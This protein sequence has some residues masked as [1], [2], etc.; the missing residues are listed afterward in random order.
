MAHELILAINAGSTSLKFGVYGLTPEGR[1]IE[2]ARGAVEEGEGGHLFV[3]ARA[4]DGRV[5]PV[6]T[7]PHAAGEAWTHESLATVLLE[8]TEQVM[9][10]ARVVAVGH[11]VVHGGMHFSAPV[12]V[13]PAVMQALESLVPLAPLH[14][15][16]NLTPIRRLASDRPGLL[17]VAAFDTDFH[18]TQTRAARLYAL[19]RAWYEEGVRRYGFHGLSCAYVVRALGRHR[20]APLDERAVIAHLGGGASISGTVGGRSVASSMGL[21]VVDGLPMAT[22]SGAIDPG[23]VLHLQKTRGLTPEAMETILYTQSGLKGLSG[24]SGDMRALLSSPEESAH[25]AVEHFVARTAREIA[26]TAADIGGLEVLVFTGGI[27]ENQPD[28]RSRIAER[29]RWTGLVLDPAR[30]AASAR[31]EPARISADESAVAA[32]VVPTD[33]ESMIAEAA[34][35]AWRADRAMPDASFT[36]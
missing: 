5:L 22:R 6:P 35:R 20:G 8:W 19:P 15:P 29:L 2:E 24:I 23:L 27:G 7:L 17:Q 33:E 26:A 3:R 34:A 11:R 36:G 9:A 31:G 16:Q 18:Q 12:V 10:G 32:W 28:T 13:T 1:T 21:T 25:E 30:N 14:Q 4:A